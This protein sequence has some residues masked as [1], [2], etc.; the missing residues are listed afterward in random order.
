[1]RPSHFV[2][3]VAGGAAVGLIGFVSAPRREPSARAPATAPDPRVAELA[4]RLDQIT[5][6]LERID[7]LA[8]QLDRVGQMAER[9]EE[10]DARLT[11]IANR[12]AA[13]TGQSTADVPMETLRLRA[14][15]LSMDAS[16]RTDA[17]EA[18]GA[19]AEW[20]ADTE[21]RTEALF[22]QGK[23]YQELKDW[24]H[25]A[26]S[27]RKVVETAGLRTERG[28][29]AAYQLGWCECWSRDNAAAY[30]TFRQL[31]ETPGLPKSVEAAARLQTASFAS[32]T[33]DVRT[34]RREYERL[35]SDYA[36]DDVEHY[37]K[38]ARAAADNLREMR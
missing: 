11:E 28:Q 22:E 17:I 8:E 24:N 27:F 1:M 35:V 14:K 23:A 18:W 9:L 4:A 26:A 31:A 33:G 21:Q 15:A 36:N 29:D 5:P 30:Q 38:I 37:R 32:A 10:I 25:A 20:A 3:L 13:A 6:Q 2:F 7:R 16:R 34:A 19:V 12:S